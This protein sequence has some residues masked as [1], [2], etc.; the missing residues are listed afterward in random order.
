MDNRHVRRLLTTIDTRRPA[1]RA[2][3]SYLVRTAFYLFLQHEG[4][5]HDPAI[6]DVALEAYQQS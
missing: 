4:R 2:Q 5:R 6:Y 1:S 3:S